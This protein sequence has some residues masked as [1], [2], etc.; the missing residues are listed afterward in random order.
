M[1]QKIISDNNFHVLEKELTD[2]YSFYHNKK[3]VNITTQLDLY[4]ETIEL[5]RLDFYTMNMKINIFGALVK[6]MSYSSLEEVK[7]TNTLLRVLEV[8]DKEKSRK[9]LKELL[10]Y[11]NNYLSSTSDPISKSEEK[12]MFHKVINQFFIDVLSENSEKFLNIKE[13]LTYECIQHIHKNT[14]LY[15]NYM[16]MSSLLDNIINDRDR[17]IQSICDMSYI[18]NNP[19]AINYLLTRNYDWSQREDSLV[20]ILTT[21]ENI[22]KFNKKVLTEEKVIRNYIK[23]KT[24]GDEIKI[25][26]LN[27]TLVLQKGKGPECPS[28]YNFVFEN[29]EKINREIFIDYFIYFMKDEQKNKEL[30]PLE[31]ALE[32]LQMKFSAQE[33]QEI[34]KDSNSLNLLRP[35]GI[36]LIDKIF[37]GVEGQLREE[38]LEKILSQAHYDIDLLTSF[39]D[40]NELIAASSKDI[41]LETFIKILNKYPEENLIKKYNGTDWALLYLKNLDNFTKED[42]KYIL[43]RVCE[44]DIKEENILSFVNKTINQ[45]SPQDKIK[46]GEIFED[47][48]F[49]GY[50]Q[51]MHSYIKSNRVILKSENMPVNIARHNYIKAKQVA[52]S[53]FAQVL[54]NKINNWYIKTYDSVTDMPIYKIFDLKVQEE[55]SLT[56]YQKEQGF[57]HSLLNVFS[58]DSL[59][60]RYIKNNNNVRYAIVTPGQATLYTNNRDTAV[61]DFTLSQDPQAIDRVQNY[62]RDNRNEKF[63]LNYQLGV[64]NL[65]ISL[66]IFIKEIEEVK[67]ISLTLSKSYHDLTHTIP[68]Y[69]EES[70]KLYNVNL[71]KTKYNQSMESVGTSMVENINLIQKYFQEIKEQVENELSDSGIKDI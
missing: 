6:H 65:I 27:N 20:N 7:L 59:Y 60:T 26:A 3:K 15:G 70:Y 9:L 17:K 34:I 2:L 49:V 37:K 48:V 29:A 66:K 8:L 31:K 16:D 38:V 13:E 41:K 4:N 18:T 58:K 57:M 54:D 5:L 1:T 33:L 69:I 43:K 32:K 23:N 35:Q 62:I 53:I 55:K 12:W 22:N 19:E 64:D 45:F 10:I 46:M 11:Y 52:H 71:K 42:K 25:Y 39:F 47:M 51:A 67:D 21:K 61:L 63:D 36:N 30:A 40:K 24:V 14:L 28:I 44:K 68:Q 56:S 50:L